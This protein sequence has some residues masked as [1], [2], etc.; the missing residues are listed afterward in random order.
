MKR[1]HERATKEVRSHPLH[2]SLTSLSTVPRSSTLAEWHRFDED[3]G[4]TS[5]ASSSDALSGTPSSGYPPAHPRP[6]EPVEGLPEDSPPMVDPF[7]EPD[8]A[9]GGDND[10]LEVARFFFVFFRLLEGGGLGESWCPCCAPNSEANINDSVGRSSS[11]FTS[12]VPTHPYLFCWHLLGG[13]SAT[14][15]AHI[16]CWPPL[17]AAAR[18]SPL[19]RSGRRL[20]P[21][22]D[23]SLSSV[24]RAPTQEPCS[25]RSPLSW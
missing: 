11:S 22:F 17:L 14:R 2:R 15:I 21:L 3:V 5:I 10:R 24:R 7:A 25:S 4:I 13:G 1:W 16:P 19:S 18:P 6:R 8:A 20:W 12:V 9:A 23:P